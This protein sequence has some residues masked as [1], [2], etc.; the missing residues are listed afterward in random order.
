VND[1]DVPALLAGLKAL[2]TEHSEAARFVAAKTLNRL[3]KKSPPLK[4]AA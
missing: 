2:L 1:A 3:D 4:K